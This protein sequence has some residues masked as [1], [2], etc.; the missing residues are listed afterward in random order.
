MEG[1]VLLD[2]H[3]RDLLYVLMYRALIC[4]W[5]IRFYISTSF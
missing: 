3:E 2:A 5:Q 4:R 1:F